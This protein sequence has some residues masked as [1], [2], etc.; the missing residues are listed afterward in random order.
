MVQGLEGAVSEDSSKM[1]HEVRRVQLHPRALGFAKAKSRAKVNIIVLPWENLSMTLLNWKI[2]QIG[3]QGA[4]GTHDC[5][6]YHPTQG[7]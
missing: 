3:E 2:S 6:S 1:P 7:R 5:S 4:K